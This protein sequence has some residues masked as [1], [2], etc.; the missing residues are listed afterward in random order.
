MSARLE[1]QLARR[2]GALL[3]LLGLAERR[4]YPPV[5]VQAAPFGP[6]TQM[7]HLTVSASRPVDKL[8]RQLGKLYDVQRVEQ[9]S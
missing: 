2:P 3:R 7:V 9:R 4:G 1:I 8:V 6:A 5:R